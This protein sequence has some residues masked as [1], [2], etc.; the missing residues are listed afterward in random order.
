MVKKHWLAVASVALSCLLGPLTALPAWA[1]TQSGTNLNLTVGNLV[2]TFQNQNIK[3]GSIASSANGYDYINPGFNFETGQ[4]TG[5][6]N[7][8]DLQ[9]STDSNGQPTLSGD[10]AVLPSSGTL[11]PP[12]AQATVPAAVSESLLVLDSAGNYVVVS[13]TAATPSMVSFR[14]AI[15]TVEPQPSQPQVSLPTSVTVGSTQV[16]F[17]GSAQSGSIASAANGY[18]YINPGFN[19]E[20]GQETSGVGS[21]SDLQLSTDSSGQ[22]TLSGYVA[23]LT[24][25]ALSAPPA[26]NTVSA[27]VGDILLVLDNAG[28]YVAVEI[29]AA[30]PSMVSFQY[31]IGAAQVQVSL[32]TSVTV[33]NLQVTFSGSAQS[34]S[35]ASA[36]NG[37]DYINPGFNFETGQETSG[38]GSTSDLQLSTDSSGQPT[39]S[40]YVATL[41]S[42]ALSA[43]PAQNTVSA[44]VGDVLLVL[45]NTGHYVAVEITA[46]SPNLVSFQYGIGTAQLL[47]VSLPTSVTVGNSNLSFQGS[48][49]SGSV[50]ASSGFDFEGGQSSGS[51][52]QFSVVNGQPTLS[53][54]LAVVT[55]AGAQFATPSESSVPVAVGD[56]LLVLD[57]AGHYVVGQITAVTSNTAS[58]QYSIASSVQQPQ[59]PQGSV[60]IVMYIGNPDVSVNGQTNTIDVPPQIIGS[61]TMVPLRFMGDALGA[62][63]TWNGSTQTVTYTL[64]STNL[65]LQIGQTQAQLNG[66]TVAMDVPPTIV[67]SR[68]LVPASFISQELGYSV[69][70]DAQ[71]RKVTITNNSGQSPSNQ[72]QTGQGGVAGYYYCKDG[73]LT[74]SDGTREVTDCLDFLKLLPDGTF[75]EYGSTTVNGT[76]EVGAVEDHGTWTYSNGQVSFSDNGGQLSGW[77]PATFY[78]QYNQIEFKFNANGG[79]QT[80]LYAPTHP[81]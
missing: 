58:F 46:A 75:T 76:V 45:D 11:S 17:S 69:Q 81:F 43:P 18:D 70:W 35:I 51:D 52:L 16:T 61:R 41:T 47:R 49:Q 29:T 65:V 77:G 78:P 38:V 1:Q 32:P 42:G 36:A 59:Q 80:Y 50:S 68:T 4:E 39:L 20:T 19:F 53:G 8:S 72:S 7:G 63:V 9:L 34:G 25:G 67:D 56:L 55:S 62:T 79:Q 54:D 74:L 73:S 60:T 14:Y 57:G 66:Q 22:P 12:P 40:G 13:L 71:D 64:G 31:S 27:G 21:T 33:G 37:Y 6:F 28:H 30:T 3:S 44:G 23:T 10:L 2:V 24:S 5:G 15:G 26:Q 48:P